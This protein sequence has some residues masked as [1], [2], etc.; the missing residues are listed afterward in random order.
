[1]IPAVLFWAARLTAWKEREPN[2][3]TLGYY[4]KGGKSTLPAIPLPRAAESFPC[5]EARDG[6]F[7]AFQLPG[8]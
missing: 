8:T 7:A 2:S 3:R 5:Q 1:M 6:L 4:P